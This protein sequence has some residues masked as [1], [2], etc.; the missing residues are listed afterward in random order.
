MP[1]HTPHQKKI[2]E[3]YYVRRDQIMLDRLG[4]IVSDLYVADSEAKLNRLWIRAQSAME[5]LEIPPRLAEHI[6]ARRK[7]EILAANLKDWLEAASKPREKRRP[8]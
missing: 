5:A 7:P 6:L 1:D 8:G 3:H 4:T 2:I